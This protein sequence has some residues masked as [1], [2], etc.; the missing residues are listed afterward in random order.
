MRQFIFL[1]LTILVFALAGCSQTRKGMTDKVSEPAVTKVVDQNIPT[2]KITW[3]TWEEAHAANKKNP[4][5]IFIDIYTDWCGWCKKMDKSTF[6]DPTIIKALNRDFYA[7]KLDAEMKEEITFNDAVFK[8]TPQGRN[9]THQLAHALLDGRMSFPAFVTL[10]EQ[11]NRIMTSPGYKQVPQLMKELNYAS[12]NSYKKMNL[13][14]YSG[15]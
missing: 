14:A 1:T 6:V 4:K 2:D 12:T 8:W 10:D 11:F 15:E 9:G 3:M 13:D 7:I 5:K